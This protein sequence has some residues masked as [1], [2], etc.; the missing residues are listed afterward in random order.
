LLQLVQQGIHDQI[1][2][3]CLQRLGEQRTDCWRKVSER[4]Q[5]SGCAQ[6][7]TTADQ[8]PRLRGQLRS[9]R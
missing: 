8:H 7:V 2:F 3:T 4:T 6:C 9:D 1:P 5:R